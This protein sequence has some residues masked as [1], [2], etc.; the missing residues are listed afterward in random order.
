MDLT[1][2][3]SRLDGVQ[4]KHGY[5]IARCPAHDDSQPSL[6]ITEGRDGRVV[7]KC[8]GGCDFDSILGAL[9]LDQGALSG[10]RREE[11]KRDEVTDVYKYVDE[12]GEVLY[13]VL[14]YYPKSFRQR[15]PV[16]SGYEWKLGDVRRVLYRLPSILVLDDDDTIYL[17]EGEKDADRL[18]REGVNAT[19]WAG[20]AGAWGQ[21]AEHANE[22]LAHQNV[23]VVADNDEP[24]FK[25][26]DTIRATLTNA[27]TVTVLKAAAGKD[28]SD[29]LNAGLALDALVPVGAKVETK[30]A[31]IFTTFDTMEDE[32]YEWAW[33][34][35]IPYGELTIL[36]GQP[37]AGKTAVLL[38]IAARLSRGHAMPDGFHSDPI[39]VGMIATEDSA[40]K[41]LRP[42]LRV[43][44]ADM[45][46]V[47]IIDQVP[48]M[49]AEGTIAEE[50]RTPVFPTDFQTVKD[51]LVE[52]QVKL[53]II[54]G[55]QH[56]I[57]QKLSMNSTQDISHIL[58]PF[59]RMAKETGMA[60]VIIRHLRKGAAGGV[61]GGLGSIGITGIARAELHVSKELDD[62]NNYTGFRV[63][64]QAKT[65]ICGEVP[66][67]RYTIQDRDGVADV[68]W[69]TEARTIDLRERDRELSMRMLGEHFGKMEEM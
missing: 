18:V 11:T 66:P 65:N 37:G 13:E 35:M 57:H 42:R 46:R 32:K 21:I 63:L 10:E 50:R 3:L 69:Q 53:L 61:D 56:H 7:M 40:T 47:G 55:L 24:G 38:N 20:G 68:F 28:V 62:E 16:A 52:N 58:G 54:D 33:P 48:Y 6:S 39:T 17:V 23:I 5:H 34:S 64:A 2:L 27:K 36:S 44:G 15:R 29:H 67:L 31:P 45:A 59:A 4:R 9:H 1:E 8:H 60:V 30:A 25:C 19:T 12:F 51:S 49:T 14:R 26:A 22:V 43:A 41:T